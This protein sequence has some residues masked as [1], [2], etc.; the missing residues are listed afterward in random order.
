MGRYKR[1]YTSPNSGYKY[2][3]V[4]LLMSPLE[5]IREPLGSWVIAS[6]SQ[7]NACVVRYANNHVEQPFTAMKL[8]LI[9]PGSFRK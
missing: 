2:S 7:V 3:I 8:T 9:P 5:T 6:E 4:I 1:G